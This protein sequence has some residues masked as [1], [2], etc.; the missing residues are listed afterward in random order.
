MDIEQL[1]LVIAMLS[2]A[3]EGI[4]LITILWIGKDYFVTLVV[5]I[6]IL[7][8]LFLLFRFA[9]KLN[10]DCARKAVEQ[11]SGTTFKEY[12]EECVMSNFWDNVKTY[13][14]KK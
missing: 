5:S 2:N 10:T 8:A 4:F 6:T 12:T 3:G 7:V 1:K 13:W 11:I 14:P 9:I